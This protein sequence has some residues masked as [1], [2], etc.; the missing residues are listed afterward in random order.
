MATALRKAGYVPTTERLQQLA[1]EVLAVHPHPDSTAA[2]EALYAK[3]LP[4]ADLLCE[5]FA[6]YRQQALKRYLVLTS[7]TLREE[8]RRQPAAE[9]RKARGEG[10]KEAG[11]RFDGAPAARPEGS[12]GQKRGDALEE[13]AA[14]PLSI[15][16]ALLAKEAAKRT[17]RA[18]VAKVLVVSRLDTFKLD[19]VPLGKTN[20]GHVRKW[21]RERGREARWLLLMA[22]NMPS[23]FVVGNYITPETADQFWRQALAEDAA[24]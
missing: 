12:G 15:T 5:L 24:A 10:R 18:T 19:G 8:G 17:A 1:I 6:P 4:E 9:E 2:Q 14:A 16:A 3:V 7:D 13:S 22:G 23:E 21:A 20:F 11:T